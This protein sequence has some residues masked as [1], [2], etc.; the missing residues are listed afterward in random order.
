MTYPHGLPAI[1]AA[2]GNPF[3]FCDDK[4]A[5][6]AQTLVTRVLKHPLPYA[7]HEGVTVTRIRAHR[8]IVDVLVE[9][10]AKA[11]ELPGVSIDRLR[12]G[13]SYCWRAMRGGMQLSTHTWGIAVD[14]DPAR[15]QRGTPHNPAIGLPMQVIELFEDAGWT[16]GARWSVPDPMHAQAGDGY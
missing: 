10:L 14:L 4:S 12:Y 2:Y 7:Y 11:V 5:W 15:N 13:G 9:L 16:S 8:L 6:E 1:L 3:P